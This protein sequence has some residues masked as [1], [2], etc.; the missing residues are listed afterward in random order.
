MRDLHRRAVDPHSSWLQSSWQA[1][2]AAQL[3]GL[4]VPTVVVSGS[5]NRPRA[6]RRTVAAFVAKPTQLF[7]LPDQGQTFAIY[8][9][10][11]QRRTY[12]ARSHRA[13]LR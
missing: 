4:N 7:K 12:T 5:S 2:P 6:S 11:G 8:V 3:R 1:S 9:T 10:A 13:S